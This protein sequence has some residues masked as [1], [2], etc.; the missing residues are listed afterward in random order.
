MKEYEAMQRKFEVE[1]TAKN[2][3]YYFIL[4]AGHF[5]EYAAYCKT[6]SEVTHRS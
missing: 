4:D 6:E 5:N 3:A 2:R 1:K